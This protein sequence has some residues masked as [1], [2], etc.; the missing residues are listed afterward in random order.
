M[1][2]DGAPRIGAHMKPCCFCIPRIFA[3]RWLNLS[4]SDCVLAFYDA[5]GVITDLRL[6][7]LLEGA[8]FGWSICRGP[9]EHQADGELCGPSRHRL[10][11]K[12]VGQFPRGLDESLRLL[13]VKP[14]P[15]PSMAASR[16]WG[17]A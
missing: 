1:L 8:G 3:A 15:A 5:K 11:L 9:Q 6:L 13:G 17:N 7:A 4:R 16:D 12:G 2:G 10:E 14:I